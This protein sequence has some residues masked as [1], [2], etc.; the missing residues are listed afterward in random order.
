MVGTSGAMPGCHVA[1]PVTAVAPEGGRT[2][3][4][5]PGKLRWL[6]QG[7]APARK[8][9]E[10]VVGAVGGSRTY[11]RL[12]AEP[13]GSPVASAGYLVDFLTLSSNL[14]QVN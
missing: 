3:P 13:A 14:G 1:C 6:A 11:Y 10:G 5:G 4:T 8:G 12:P 9:P 7:L 2:Q